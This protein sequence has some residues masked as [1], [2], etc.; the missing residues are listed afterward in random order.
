MFSVGP[1]CPGNIAGRLTKGYNHVSGVPAPRDP[2]HRPTHFQAK[3]ASIEAIVR[4]R[5]GSSESISKSISTTTPSRS[6]M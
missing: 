3:V 5:S 2:A 4:L 6:M 1:A